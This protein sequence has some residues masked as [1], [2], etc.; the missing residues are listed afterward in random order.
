MF[1]GQ[2]TEGAAASV[3]RPVV[4]SPAGG[5]APC[6]VHVLHVRDAGPAPLPH[7]AGRGMGLPAA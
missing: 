1:P 5:E 7:P 2:P 6:A 4:K 3:V